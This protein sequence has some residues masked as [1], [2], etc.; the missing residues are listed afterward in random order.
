MLAGIKGGSAA[1]RAGEFQKKSLGKM[2]AV[3]KS[4]RTVLFVSHNM[5][6]ISNLC[7]RAIFLKSG[8]ICFQGKTHLAIEKYINDSGTNPGSV[9]WVNQKAPS[10]D[11][12]KL[13][14]VK[15]IS[16]EKIT[17]EIS[18]DKPILI[19]IKYQNLKYNDLRKIF[20]RFDTN[21]QIKPLKRD[22][23]HF[24]KVTEKEYN[25]KLVKENEQ[26]KK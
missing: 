11:N 14:S 1:L 12:V 24:F 13:L 6:A 5:A 3:A 8:K 20:S 21:N 26:W 18:I 9:S 7:Q 15:I 4:G 10:T 22:I 17:A 25:K 19:V 23:E 2:Q 16:E